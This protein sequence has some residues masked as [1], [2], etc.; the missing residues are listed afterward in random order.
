MTDPAR[1]KAD[2][3]AYLATPGEGV[4]KT[5]ESLLR[6]TL[7]FLGDQR[8][9]FRSGFNAVIKGGRD[10]AFA[11]HMAERDYDWEF[12]AKGT[13]AADLEP[14][15]WAAYTKATVTTEG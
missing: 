15:A 14:Q 6:Q 8:E 2:I 11:A 7:P 1:L 13:S 5:L 9:A 3:E 12:P 4:V 10:G